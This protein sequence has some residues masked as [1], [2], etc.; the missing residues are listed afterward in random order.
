MNKLTQ[1]LM[2]SRSVEAFLRHHGGRVRWQSV[3]SMKVESDRLAHTD[4]KDASKLVDRVEALAALIRDPRIDAFAQASRAR[5]LHIEGKHGAANRL[6]QLAVA[7]L[8][9]FNL[10]V[11]AARIQK[12]QVDALTELGRYDEALGAAREARR[13]LARQG[14]VQLAQLET[15]VG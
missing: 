8:R 2:R 11:E 4:L 12:Q 3:A 7:G 10:E 14:S 9:S 1:Q 5:L 13:V 6:Y 15:N